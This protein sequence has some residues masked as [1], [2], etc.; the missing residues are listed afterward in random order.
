MSTL[1]PYVSYN[2]NA[3]AAF[4]FYHKVFGGD[5][6]Q[7]MRWGDNP[8][9][10]DY[11]AEDKNRVMH[12]RLQIGDSEIMASDHVDGIGEKYV[13]GNNF[14]VAISPASKEEADRFF[15]GLSEGGKDAM[16]MQDMFW[17]GYYGH[18]TDKFGIRWMLNYE[19]PK[20]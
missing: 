17:G 1:N 11:S 4:N 9:C 20:S 2:G 8:Q 3:E 14:A 6:P 16:P 7:F 13:P 19:T 10:A 15:K 18:V 5:A 12:T